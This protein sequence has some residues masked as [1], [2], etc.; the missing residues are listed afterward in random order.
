VGGFEVKDILLDTHVWIWFCLEEKKAFSKKGLTLIQQG[1]QKWISAISCW[2][3]AKLSEKGRIGFSIPV[4]TWIRRSLNEYGINVAD[5]SPEI[6]VEST[7]LKGFHKDPAD[8]IIVATSR[9]LAMPL[10]TSD[11]RILNCKDVETVW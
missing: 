8:Q 10:L 4:F 11:R 2:E 9:V 7:Q 3:L 6:S 5:L 1:G